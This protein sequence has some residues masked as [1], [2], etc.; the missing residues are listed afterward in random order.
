M[1]TDKKFQKKYIN[2]N[3][4]FLRRSNKK[5]YNPIDD[6]YKF[7]KS[8]GEY[9]SDAQMSEYSGQLNIYPHASD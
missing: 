7:G 8:I 3:N 9:D 1:K 4:K 6:E 5:R 2:A